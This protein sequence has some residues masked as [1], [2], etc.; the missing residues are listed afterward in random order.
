MFR[1]AEMKNI[2]AKRKMQLLSVAKC[3][4]SSPISGLGFDFDLSLTQVDLVLL[5]LGPRVQD[6]ESSGDKPG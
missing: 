3:L 6:D 4:T 1:V 5:D 2:T